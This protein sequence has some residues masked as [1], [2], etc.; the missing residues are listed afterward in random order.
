MKRKDSERSFVLGFHI[1][2]YNLVPKPSKN[3]VV[4][5]DWA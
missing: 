1:L 5:S 2:P 4:R 3:G